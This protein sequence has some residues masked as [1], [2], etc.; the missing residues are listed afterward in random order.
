MYN[1]QVYGYLYHLNDVKMF[2]MI[3]EDYIKSIH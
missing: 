3:Y 2:I 1:D